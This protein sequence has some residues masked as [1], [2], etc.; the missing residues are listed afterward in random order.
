[1]VV[2]CC[3]RALEAGVVPGMPLAEAQTL[4]GSEPPTPADVARPTVAPDPLSS[5]PAH[6]AACFF[7]EEPEADRAAL[8]Q[9]AR[10]CTRFTP[11]VGVEPF[12]D[13]PYGCLDSLLLDVTG[14]AHLF[15][16]EWRLAGRVAVA[17]HKKGFS[18]R[19]GL[20]G[21]VGAAWALAHW[22][23]TVEQRPR[24][25]SGLPVE[26][27]RLSV[28][29]AQTLHQLGL[30]TV[31]QLERLPRE[32]LRRR[33]GPQLLTRL[34]QLR[35]RTPEPVEAI[36]LPEPLEATRVFDYPV[37][38]LRAVK[39][40]VREL[41]QELVRKRPHPH[42]GLLRLRVTLTGEAETVDTPHRQAGDPSV[43]TE[44][45]TFCVGVVEPSVSVEH[46]LELV[47]LHLERRRTHTPV[48]SV[49]VCVEQTAPLPNRQQTLF[50]SD[51]GLSCSSS[52]GEGRRRWAELLDRLAHRLGSHS[53]LRPR[54]QPDA[55]PELAVEYEPVLASTDTAAGSDGRAAAAGEGRLRTNRAGPGSG[56]ARLRSPQ[57]SPRTSNS[58]LSN[59]T[60][61]P[62]SDRVS[63]SPL[64][65]GN[66][67]LF[68]REPPEPVKVVS[69]VPEG[70]P[71]RVWLNGR[72]WQ[73]ARSWGP[74]RIETGW[75]RHRPVRRD[76]FRA[77]LSDGR[78]VW[79]FHDVDSGQW[80]LH[81]VFD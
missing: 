12:T 28:S 1:M 44:S 21:T 24:R 63:S 56:S 8:W 29:T 74:E 66:R 76:Y 48:C 42:V 25:L 31:G 7:A 17:L 32:S 54:L 59:S 41:L 46:W 14:C 78:H 9:L 71:L 15:G 16:G 37:D 50:G 11:W 75:W 64:V 26:A 20:A 53:V 79:L 13:D 73:V 36:P 52:D 22:G 70:A 10:L 40:V 61:P 5:S 60:S 69:V 55:Q 35:G 80:F 30:H 81:G 51:C 23:A 19:L 72:P 68:L 33:F 43:Q 18:S 27:L 2:A 38:E 57:P 62:A 4:L 39:A 77:E 34:D 45:E 3:E 65:F 49:R 47:S 6:H 67:P 58:S